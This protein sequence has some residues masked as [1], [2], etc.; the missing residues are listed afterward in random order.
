MPSVAA[1]RFFD[2]TSCFTRAL[3]FTAETRRAQSVGVFTEVQFSGSVFLGVLCASAVNSLRFHRTMARNI[4]RPLFQ[5][6]WLICNL[7]WLLLVS[8]G[9]VTLLNPWHSEQFDLGVKITLGL[10]LLGAGYNMVVMI[11]LVLE[12]PDRFLPAVTVVADTILAIAFVAAS[13]GWNSWLYFFGLFPI[14]TVG[15]R[16]GW[17]VRLL[18]SA[19]II[20]SFLALSYVT[21]PREADDKTWFAVAVN[22]AV[23]A[24]A[25]LITGMVGD[26]VKGLAWQAVRAEEEAEL[27][28]LRAERERARAIFE[29]AATLG[30]T[31]SYSRVLDAILD[32]ATM[33]LKDLGPLAG[34]I[35]SMV[36]L[37]GKQGLEVSVSRRLPPRDMMVRVPGRDGLIGQ[38]LRTAEP[39]VGGAA[40]ED[41]ELGQFVALHNCQAVL[42]VPLRAGF[43]TYGVLIVGS[44]S[45]GVFTAEHVELL[46]AVC[47]QATI[48]LQN[49]Q[50]YAN[51]QQEK[52]RI[53]EV[54]EEARKKLARDLHDGPT[55]SIA[56]IAMRLNYSQKLL[57]HDPT[58]VGEELAKIEDL[59]RKTTK[60]IRHMLFT[61]RPLVLETQGLKAALETSIQ[62]IMETDSS[63]ALHLEADKFEDKID[64]NTQGVVFYI[65]EEAVGNARKHAQA[66]NIW[67]RLKLRKDAFIAQVQDDGVGFEVN[68]VQASYETRGSLGMV[69][70]RERAEL[71]N[72]LISI[73]SA[74]GKGTTVTLAVPLERK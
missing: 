62:K 27:K 66:K 68:K 69:N 6:D 20:L 49:A 51:L 58:K 3:I 8:V 65:I 11:L 25:A 13:G 59:A 28:R 71:V 37:H 72:G 14:I 4:S 42:G 57:Q 63:V 60:E 40:R 23:L 38:T 34:Q 2:F 43:E 56:A 36:L 24:V 74:P 19:S 16:F 52:E 29:M 5:V 73:D 46:A 12:M 7:R 30:A 50:L 26:R 44:P 33:G 64:M 47:S 45:P 39:V 9:I 21:L 10:L 35:V 32:V 53:I 70:L 15:L 22:A 48:A 1:T 41:P 31:L 55:Q 18:T 17:I 61:L 54:E 67:I